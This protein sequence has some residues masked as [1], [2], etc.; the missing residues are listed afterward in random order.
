M[1]C[2]KVEIIMKMNKQKTR[3]QSSELKKKKK[4]GTEI[5]GR[6]KPNGKRRKEQKSKGTKLPCCFLVWVLWETDSEARIWAQICTQNIWA[7]V[8]GNCRRG[9]ER[10]MGKERQTKRG[11]LSRLPRK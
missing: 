11:A 3:E 7:V 4:K 5:R 2:E 1:G 8:P 6:D 9:A 10:V